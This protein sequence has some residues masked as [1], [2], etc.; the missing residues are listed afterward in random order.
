VTSAGGLQLQHISLVLCL[1]WH[2]VG[3]TEL[4]GRSQPR[5]VG[6]CILGEMLGQERLPSC[7]VLAEEVGVMSAGCEVENAML[8]SW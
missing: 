1:L 3:Q 6:H 8:E 4:I 2:L 5:S 7:S